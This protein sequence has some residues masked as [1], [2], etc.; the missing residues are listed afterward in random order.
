M[1][2]VARQGVSPSRVFRPT[3]FEIDF[4]GPRVKGAVTHCLAVGMVVGFT[5]R[6][7]IVDR[8]SPDVAGKRPA[9][10]SACRRCR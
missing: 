9:S 7:R 5:T 6:F 1:A 8:P 10:S 3:G 4:T 2:F